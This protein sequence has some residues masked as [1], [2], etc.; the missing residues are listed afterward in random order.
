[1][2]R[3]SPHDSREDAEFDFELWILLDHAHSAL[4]RARELELTQF[5]L[6]P[7]QAAVD[8]NMFL[9]L[10][11]SHLKQMYVTADPALTAIEI[12]TDAY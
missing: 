9:H 2:I 1:M 8:L 6:T 11:V 7:E 4:S 3:E 5:G 10:M 12:L